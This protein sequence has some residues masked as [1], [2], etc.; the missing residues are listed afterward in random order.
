MT[1]NLLEFKIYLC[2]YSLLLNTY[3]QD[4]M[5]IQS[6]P[7]NTQHILVNGK[8]MSVNPKDWDSVSGKKRIFFVPSQ[9]SG[10]LH[11][12][13]DLSGLKITYDDLKKLVFPKNLVY[14]NLSNIKITAAELNGLNLSDKVQVLILN[15]NKL[16]HSTS[17][18]AVSSEAVSTEAVSTEAVSSEAVSTGAVSSE[19]VSTG[20]VS[21]EAVSTEAVSTEAVSSEAVSSEAVSTEAVASTN[22]LFSLIKKFPKIRALYLNNCGITTEIVKTV[23]F[24]DTL[25]CLSLKDN[26]G[27]SREREETESKHLKRLGLENSLLWTIL[28]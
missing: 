1:Y 20:A 28:F 3:R 14:L 15:H 10:E 24:P 7:V 13:L 11:I 2:K 21:S 25:R 18:G 26:I 12:G 6:K 16:C 9:L 17:T 27:L 19:A 4:N 23:S 5:T 8:T 22:I